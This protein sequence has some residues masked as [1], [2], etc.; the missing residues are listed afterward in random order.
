M[1]RDLDIQNLDIQKCKYMYCYNLYVF[2]ECSSG[3]FEFE[4]SSQEAGQ[5]TFF[6][7]IKHRL[8]LFACFSF[9]VHTSISKNIG[10]LY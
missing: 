7:G 4:Y 9:C 6:F 3:F 10:K 5:P 2:I 1:N 8:A